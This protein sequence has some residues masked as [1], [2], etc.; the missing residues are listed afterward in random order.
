MKFRLRKT[1]FGIQP[2]SD[3]D[4]QK[5]GTIEYG[6]VFECRGLDQR[7]VKHHRKFF[8]MVNL[9]FQNM[10][11]QYDNHFPTPEHLREELIKRAGYYTKYTNFKGETEYKA[12]SIRFDNM[13]Q[14]KFEQLYS[15]VLDVIIKWLI[16]IEK[17]KLDQEILNFMG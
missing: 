4:K 11:E 17:D 13:G 10:P 9:A 16:P 15:D 5:W 1:E 7:N 2:V 8:A 6:E 12:E 3:E 14:A